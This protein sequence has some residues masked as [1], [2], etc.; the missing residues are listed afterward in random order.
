MSR[1]PL[2]PRD[3]DLAAMTDEDFQQLCHRLVLLEYPEALSTDNPDSGADSVLPASSGGWTQAWQ[4]K[5]YGGTIYW[6]K[7]KDSLDR[8][9]KHYEIDQMTFCFPRNLTAGQHKK[10]D[11][12]LVGRHKDVSVGL[13]DRDKLL[14]KLNGSED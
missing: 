2:G 13:W 9:V 4:A 14:S 1:K 10:F 8:A 3:L 11:K 12:E 7:C 5:R 6:S